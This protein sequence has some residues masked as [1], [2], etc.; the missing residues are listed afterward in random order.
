LILPRKKITWLGIIALVLVVVLFLI[1]TYR[2]KEEKQA[3]AS[4]STI[5]SSPA[6]VQNFE[7]KDSDGDGLM[8]WEEVL[9]H[10]DPHNPDTDG[11]GTPDGEEVKE[12]RDPT[13]PGP[14]DKLKPG[15][16]TDAGSVAENVSTSNSSASSTP[17]TVTSKAAIDL[18]QKYMDLKQSGAQI[19]PDLENALVESVLSNATVQVGQSKVYTASDF[20]VSSDSSQQALRDYANSLGLILKQNSP[21]EGSDNEVTILMQ[22]AQS[23]DMSSASKLDPIVNGYIGIMKAMLAMNVPSSIVSLHA[24]LLTSI[25]AVEKNIAGF[26]TMQ[27]DPLNAAAQLNAYPQNVENMAQA[28]DQMSAFLTQ[29]GLTFNSNEGGSV[30]VHTGG[31]VQL[32][33]TDSTDQ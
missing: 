27:D 13:I 29:Q 22:I 33:S 10:T 9:W 14:N 23:S 30:L 25:A 26:Q 12:G 21:P 7:D 6:L 3:V 16:S 8:D 31:A 5:S 20:K 24:T 19:S 15:N 17:D 11:D 18:F 32:D 28:F 1:F 4:A 2:N